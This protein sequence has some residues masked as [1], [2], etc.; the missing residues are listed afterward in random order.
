MICRTG[1]TGEEGAEIIVDA[2]AAVPLWKS[3]TSAGAT[4]CGLGARDLLRTEVGYPLYGHE[5]D[6]ETTPAEAGLNWAVT[7]TLPF[8]GHDRCKRKAKELTGFVTADRQ[9]VR[10]G[11]T[12]HDVATGNRV[13]EVTSGVFSPHRNANLGMAYV[14]CSYTKEHDTVLID[15]RGRRVEA[16]L[17]SKRKLLSGA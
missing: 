12:V 16:S 10:Q 17:V 11:Y 2:A 5:I 1:Y 7:S 15:I 14:P 9:P 6:E 4:A 3:L 8:I 13:G